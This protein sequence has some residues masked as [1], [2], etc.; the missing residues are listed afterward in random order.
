VVE[1]SE[2]SAGVSAILHGAKAQQWAR[3]QDKLDLLDFYLCASWQRGPRWTRQAMPGEPLDRAR[4]DCVYGNNRCE[5]FD[6]IEY[7]D[8][9]SWQTLSD[10]IPIVIQIVLAV[11]E[12]Q[13]MRKSTYYKYD[14]S[15]FNTAAFKEAARLNWESAASCESPKRHWETGWQRIS[16]LMLDEQNKRRVHAK[17][18]LDC[19]CNLRS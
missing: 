19:D 10:H 14:H 2:D 12:T 8:H 1:F 3:A 9:N 18:L 6:H 11:Q 13:G 7:I 15:Y 5:W 17:T 4:L 16:Q